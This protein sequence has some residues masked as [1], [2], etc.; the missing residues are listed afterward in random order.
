MYISVPITCMM[1]FAV[2]LNSEL[3]PVHVYTPS[4]DGYCALTMCRV[5]MTVPNV[6]PLSVPR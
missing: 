2:E 3:L 4:F 5:D 6:T 1:T